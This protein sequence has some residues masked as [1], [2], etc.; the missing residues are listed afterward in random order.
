MIKKNWDITK[1]WLSFN[2]AKHGITGWSQLIQ[3]M[4]YKLK[5]IFFSLSLGLLGLAPAIS[6]A[7]ETSVQQ[8]LE[9]L[10]RQLEQQQKMMQQQQTLIQEMQRQLNQQAAAAKA[11][12]QATQGTAKDSTGV[13]KKSVATTKDVAKKEVKSVEQMVEGTVEH[14]TSVI[15]Q[16]EGTAET[17]VEGTEKVA[18]TAVKLPIESVKRVTQNMGVNL[19]QEM[20]RYKGKGTTIKVPKVDT[21]LTIGGFI[22]A[23][24]IH[25]FNAIES[26]YKFVAKDIVVNGQPSGVPD[27]RT[28]FTANT[29]RLFFSSATPLSVGQLTTFFS[30]DLAGNTTSASPEFRFR[31]GWA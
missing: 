22:R 8:Q 15:K 17:I 10:A 3:A 12:Q 30:F 13:V 9:T 31:Q 1:L 11:T 19:S 29:S 28:T 5:L 16:V 23:S 27:K 21:A 26:P 4:L 24:F 14:P 18:V 20:F 25:D 2:L 6:M 7:D